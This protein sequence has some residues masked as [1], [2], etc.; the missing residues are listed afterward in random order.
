MMRVQARRAAAQR[1]QSYDTPAGEESSHGS[2]MYHGLPYA[3]I[4]LR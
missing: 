2:E 1:Q 3:K 4:K